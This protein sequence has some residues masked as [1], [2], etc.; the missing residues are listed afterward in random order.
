MWL[1]RCSGCGSFSCSQNQTWWVVSLLCSVL[2]EE[3]NGTGA[4]TLTDCQQLPSRAFVVI[5]LHQ[6]GLVL[7]WPCHFRVAQL[8]SA[9][10]TARGAAA[11]HSAWPAAAT[12]WRH[13]SSRA[14]WVE[15][16][17]PR[18]ALLGGHKGTKEMSTVP[19][20]WP[21]NQLGWNRPLRSSP[22]YDLTP[23]CQH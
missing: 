3:S 21:Q 8:P 12:A 18:T 22:I 7:C 14:T 15:G 11:S 16:A 9:A 2:C 10:T 19:H 6:K 20:Q 1:N 23:P 4:F 17:E 13:R 5:L